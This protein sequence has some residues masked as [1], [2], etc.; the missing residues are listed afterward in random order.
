M[1][2]F[3][4]LFPRVLVRAVVLIALA[5]PAMPTSPNAASAQTPPARLRIATRIVPPLVVRNEDGRLS[6]FSVELWNG[7][8]ANAKL[9]FDYVVKDTLP[10]LLA[11][12]RTGE[13]D[14]A[15]AAVSITSQ[16][17]AEFDFSLPTTDAGL[18]ILVREPSQ[19]TGVAQ[20]LKALLSSPQLY[21]LLGIL[22]MLA[23]LPVPFVWWAERRRGDGFIEEGSGRRQGLAKTLFWSLATLGG[24]AEEMPASVVGRVAAVV[25]IFVS[26]LFIS[27]FTATTT[28]I[29]TVREL[30]DTIR[31]PADL[32]GRT[33]AT[34]AGSTAEAYLSGEGVRTLLAPRI[35]DA[36][37]Q[38]ESGAAD[39]V[40]YDSPVLL[41]RASHVGSGKV[42]VAGPVFRK[43]SYGV[44]LPSGSRLRKPINAALLALQESGAYRAVYV[45]WFGRE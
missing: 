15:V 14:A 31:G 21:E 44:L 8:A 20:S 40:V 29:L 18:Q 2:R 13:V 5:L 38:L 41:Y 35:E 1:F 28:T 10:E 6:G 3:S 22:L 26:V 30:S 42:R 4:H 39:A 24:Q 32:P 11:A 25:T 12:V 36:V 43:E 23:F 17:E 45:K 19:N 37:A 27:Y 7:I 9:S 34:V 16:R 33:I